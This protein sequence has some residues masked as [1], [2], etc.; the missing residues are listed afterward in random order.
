MRLER[1]IGRE[2]QRLIVR[3]ENIARLIAEENRRRELRST[4]PVLV[5]RP[6]RPRHWGLAPGFNP[7]LARSRVERLA[8][9]I[10]Q[11]LQ[12][13]T[14][15]PHPPAQFFVPKP[16]GG[17]RP[18][19]IYQVADAAISKMLF[20]G[21]L[22]KN[23]PLLSA[24]AYA[25]R[26]DV[27]AQDAIQY[28][29]SEFRGRTRLFIAEYDFRSYFDNIDHEHVRQMLRDHFLLTEVERS[30]IENFLVTGSCPPTGYLNEDGPKRDRGIPQGTSISLLLANVAAWQLDRTLETIGVGF[31][32]YADD[33][34]MW[35]PD[36][37]RICD[38]VEQLHRHALA[39]GV[40]I[41]TE[42]SPGIRLLTTID[43]H[44]EMESTSS[45]DYLGYSLGL[46]AIGIKS[47]A[48]QKMRRRIANLIYWTLIHEPKHKTQRL[49]RL[50]TAVDQD[51]VS[52]I[53]RLRRYL[54]GDLSEKAVRRY[55]RSEVPLRRF[56]GI[57][58]AYPL[59]DDTEELREF[60]LWIRTQ[61]WLAL[62]QRAEL[63]S[64]NGAP[65]PLPA[66]H[67]LSMA[68]LGKLSAQSA[69]TGGRI[70]LTFPSARRIARVIQRAAAEHGASAIG[71]SR[72]YDY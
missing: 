10:R 12:N 59:A 54:Y 6:T 34:L 64:A 42:K 14:Y 8:H 1:E 55:Q 39:I 63:L 31:T 58:S 50:S 22:K 36:Y 61:V 11:Q 24:R 3:H 15:A 56:K 30:A 4:A 26:K 48:M 5:P 41:N 60:D 21:V 23:L 69:R 72:P 7:Y 18:I 51:Y 71:R 43:G 44:A 49:S 52:L 62:R 68:Q 53:W 46:T 32:R 29:K 13:R 28:V 35:S 57:M 16:S 66:P 33:T 65:S 70:D 37:S 17:E 38:A 40:A 20:E 67:G 27:S 25:Y 45:I 47:A 19:C 2:A 9:A